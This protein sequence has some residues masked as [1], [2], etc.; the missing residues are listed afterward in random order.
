MDFLIFLY[1]SL[2][3]GLF[4]YLGGQGG[5]WYKSSW[6]RD[7]ICPLIIIACLPYHWSL[8]VCYPLTIGALSTYWKKKGTDAQWYNWFLH[9]L[10]IGLALIP[11]GIFIHAISAVLCR[12]IIL[13]ISM[14]VWSHFIHKDWLDEG[15]RGSLII[16]TLYLF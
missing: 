13:G 8:W 12:A 14:A 7:Y 1:Y 3:C 10:G 5:A 6:I 11:Y 2:I 15:G 16:A 4:Y 9:G